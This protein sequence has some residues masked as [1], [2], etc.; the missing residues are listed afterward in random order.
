[1]KYNDQSTMDKINRKLNNKYIGVGPMLL[2]G[3]IA[4]IIIYYYIFSS[5]GNNDDGSASS[6]K[7]FFE[8]TLWLLFI[9]LL[10]LNGISYIFGID[11]LKTV[12]M[13]FGTD[14]GH[15]LD[16]KGQRLTE[17][18]DGDTDDE[19]DDDDEL[20]IM[21]K[22][23]DFH[24]PENKYNYDDAKAVCK[25][26]GARLA[27]YDEMSKALDKGADWCTYGWS[28]DQMALFPTQMEKWERLQKQKGHEQ[29]CGRPGV[30]GAY[31]NDPAMNYGANCFGSKPSVTNA[32]VQKMRNKSEIHK[33][34]KE[35][36]FDE[37]V[38]FWKGKTNEIAMSPF[39]HDNWSM[40]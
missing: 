17:G 15:L 20:R 7:I 27:T 11:L 19:G 16:D 24:L 14:R 40:L 33:T 37:R 1:M 39:N 38:K 29:D 23:Q 9:V 22:E 10:L 12:D 31:V 6:M 34:K 18:E 21:L 2:I 26:Y 28:D 35:L 5:L 25:A 8:T 4:V 36:E 3:V 30:N 13:N 32:D